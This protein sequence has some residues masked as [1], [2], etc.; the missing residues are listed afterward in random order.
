[1]VKGRKKEMLFSFLRSMSLIKRFSE[2]F[3]FCLL[4]NYDH[5]LKDLSLLI[6]RCLGVDSGRYQPF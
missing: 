1:M 3:L 4:C 5:L 6:V 2:L